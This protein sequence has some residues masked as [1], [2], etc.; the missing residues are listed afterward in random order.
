MNVSTKLKINARVT[1]TTFHSLYLVV[2][3]F[4]TVGDYTEKSQ[5][6]GQVLDSLSLAC[7]GGACRSSSKVHGQGL[8]TSKKAKRPS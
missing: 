4:A 8:R 5:C 3:A 7:T 6:F 1:L 2:H